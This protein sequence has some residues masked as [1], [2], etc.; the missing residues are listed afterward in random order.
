LRQPEGTDTTRQ[1]FLGPVD[2]KKS[3][4]D[5]ERID[6]P[7]RS[8]INSAIKGNKYDRSLPF[9]LHA[10]FRTRFWLGGVVFMASQLLQ[11]TAP[12]VSRDLL[13][14]LTESY[15]WHRLGDEARV[16]LVCVFLYLDVEWQGSDIFLARPQRSR[17]WYWP[18]LRPL[19]NARNRK[20]TQ[21][22]SA[23]LYDRSFAT[24]VTTHAA[25]LVIF[26]ALMSTGLMTR[27]AVSTTY[28][29]FSIICCLI[30]EI[31]YRNHLSQV[32]SLER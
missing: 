32:P 2:V 26:A 22:P 7:D 12:L 21:Q 28:T 15:T 25:F 18:C 4:D 10:T 17:I 20:F 13:S 14:W 1:N 6:L 19:L 9:A 8:G 5:A 3:L 29:H 27:T 16:G 30:I 11:T 31:D 24:F 23:A